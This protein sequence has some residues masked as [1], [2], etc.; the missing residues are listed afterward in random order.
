MHE[1]IFSSASPSPS[2]PREQ[3]GALGAPRSAVPGTPVGNGR[4]P[5]RPSAAKPRA[6]T[7]GTAAPSVFC[8]S[9]NVW[10]DCKYFVTGHKKI[11]VAKKKLSPL[12]ESDFTSHRKKLFGPF[13]CLSVWY[14]E[15]GDTSE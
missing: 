12:P 14:R 8:R 6:G 7:Q 9:P 15:G 2:V 3:L 4:A 13:P 10:E 1:L 5:V 11:L